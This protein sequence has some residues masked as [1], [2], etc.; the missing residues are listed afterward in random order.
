MPQLSL[1]DP[2]DAPL[3]GARRDLQ[4]AN[5]QLKSASKELAR[6]QQPEQRL[7]AVIAA[8][9]A[10]VAELAILREKDDAALVEWMTQGAVSLRPEISTLTLDAEHRVARLAKDATAA[11]TALGHLSQPFLRNRRLQNRSRGITGSG[12]R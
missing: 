6:L 7:H 12:P 8:H 3:T 5:V 9:D 4:N 1:V 10:A 11:R 2:A